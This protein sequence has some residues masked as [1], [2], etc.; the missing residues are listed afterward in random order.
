MNSKIKRLK[1]KLRADRVRSKIRGTAKVPRLSVYKSLTG[2]YAQII[3]DE[4]G[5]TLVAARSQEIQNKTT[6]TQNARK[7]GELLANKAKK[8]KIKKVKFDRGAFRYHGRIKAFAEG[9]R[10]GGLEF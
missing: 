5:Q 9:A 8:K 2:I 1:R 7:L 6:K 3:D 4:K 10:A